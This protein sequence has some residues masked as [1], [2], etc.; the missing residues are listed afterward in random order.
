MSRLACSGV[1]METSPAT[2]DQDA[3][4]GWPRTAPNQTGQST[5]VW[6]LSGSLARLVSF[7]P[8]CYYLLC[9][10][11][12]I[13]GR[14][15]STFV[16]LASF[17]TSI[18]LGTGAKYHRVSFR[19]SAVL[20]RLY[21]WSYPTGIKMPGLLWFSFHWSY[22]PSMEPFIDYSSA[23]WEISQAQELQHWHHGKS[24]SSLRLGVVN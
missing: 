20:P 17:S 14:R 8:F 7:S 19:I 24:F 22:T 15:L 1:W 6:I 5:G 3:V 13:Y 12:A 11:L 4:L 18:K 9:I 10:T 16:F 2:I 21:S 23:R